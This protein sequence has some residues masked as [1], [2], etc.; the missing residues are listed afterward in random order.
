MVWHRFLT[1]ASLPTALHSRY[2]LSLIYNL[3]QWIG[4]KKQ[5]NCTDRGLAMVPD[6]M[7][8]D[9][10]VLILDNNTINR[11]VMSPFRN[12]P[13]PPSPRPGPF[14]SKE[15]TRGTTELHVVHIGARALLDINLI[16]F[17]YIARLSQWRGGGHFPG[18][19]VPYHAASLRLRG[20]GG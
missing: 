20:G 5:A 8:R 16:W 2:S 7:H 6:T 17:G 19:Y 15:I 1:F 12:H 4:G 10:Q 13:P 11:D 18:S 14:E 3:L 9:I